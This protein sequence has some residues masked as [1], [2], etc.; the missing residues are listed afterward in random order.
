MSVQAI[1]SFFGLGLESWKPSGIEPPDFP[2]LVIDG[3]DLTEQ[4]ILS[5]A[6]LHTYDIRM[7]D[8]AFRNNPALFEKL[9][10]DYPVRREFPAYQLHLKNVNQTTSEKLKKLGFAVAN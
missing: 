10:G 3:S 5:K 7:D 4:E 2:E 9:R 8:A 6:V 1:N